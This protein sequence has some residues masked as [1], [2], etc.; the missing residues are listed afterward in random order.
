MQK[1]FSFS[2]IS[3]LFLL[4]SVFTLS[5]CTLKDQLKTKIL[6]KI[7]QKVAEERLEDLT[8]DQLLIELETN[9]ASVDTQFKT[10]ETELQ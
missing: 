4:L 9:D 6:D 1:Q 7:D 8:D 10:L 5:S 2:L 3:L